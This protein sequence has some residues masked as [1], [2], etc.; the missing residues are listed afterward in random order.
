MNEKPMT[1][2][3]LRGMLDGIANQ[4]NL[5]LNEAARWSGKYRAAEALN[6]ELASQ[7]E[8]LIVERT[9]LEAKIKKPKRPKQ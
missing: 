8:S 4:R 7:V 2:A 5:A 6:K 3:E 1:E 9:K